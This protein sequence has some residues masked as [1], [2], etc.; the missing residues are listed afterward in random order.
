MIKNLP[1]AWF[2]GALLALCST[3]LVNPVLASSVTTNS[4]PSS[5]YA[6][7]QLIA[8][9]ADLAG[10]PPS[11]ILA[12]ARVESNFNPNAKSH[13]GARGVMQIM[14]ATARGVFGID[15]DELWQPR[16]NVQLGIQYLQQLH[17]RYG[18]RWDLALSHYNGGSLRRR[19]GKTI[20]HS[21][22]RKYVTS[23]L[24]WQNHYRL[25]VAQLRR[26]PVPDSFAPTAILTLANALANASVPIQRKALAVLPQA[27][28]P[29]HA[30]VLP[31]P[32]ATARVAPQLALAQQ[33]AC[34]ADG[35]KNT[36]VL[37]RVTMRR[38][39]C[40]PALD[41]FSDGSVFERMNARRSILG[42][43]LLSPSS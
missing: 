12:V 28:L 40:L 29:R 23:V 2:Y 31:P 33:V 41:N 17:K 15:A 39:G 42:L 10:V 8:H 18:R 25:Q 24:N 21:Y 4:N 36:T 20:P 37:Q 14:P 9:E 7:Q 1:T 6:I 26:T 3:P 11:L 35:T 19:G 34:T 27:V 38:A 43:S 32:L 22:T 16:L 30:V 5:K 13:K